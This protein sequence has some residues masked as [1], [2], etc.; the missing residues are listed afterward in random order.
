MS[1]KTPVTLSSEDAQLV[2][3]AKERARAKKPIFPPLMI[4][5]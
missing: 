5:I 2:E 3:K 4:V 1:K